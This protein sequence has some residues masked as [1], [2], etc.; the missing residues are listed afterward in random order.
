MVVMP[1]MMGHFSD[2]GPGQVSRLEL[3]IVRRGQF[4]LVPAIK[5][6]CPMRCILQVRRRLKLHSVASSAAVQTG[7][8][9]AREVHAIAA[10]ALMWVLSKS[11]LLP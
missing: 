3:T 5:L 2:P 11:V 10:A 4:T 6:L 8:P 9:V 7:P 1:M